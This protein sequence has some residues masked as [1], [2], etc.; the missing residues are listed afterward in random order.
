MCCTDSFQR[1]E[2]LCIIIDNTICSFLLFRQTSMFNSNIYIY[3]YLHDSILDTIATI[4]IFPCRFWTKQTRSRSVKRRGKNSISQRFHRDFTW[5][6]RL[7]DQPGFSSEAF[8]MYDPRIMVGI[9]QT[10]RE[11]VTSL[12]G[13]FL[14]SVS[15]F[16]TIPLAGRKRY[17]AGISFERIDACQ[18]NEFHCCNVVRDSNRLEIN[19]WSIVWN[20]WSFEI[21]RN[22]RTRV[23]KIATKKM[24]TKFLS[25]W[26]IAQMATILRHSLNLLINVSFSFIHYVHF[27]TENQLFT[28]TFSMIIRKIPNLRATSKRSGDFPRGKQRWENEVKFLVSRNA[29]PPF[30]RN[31]QTSVLQ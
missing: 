2:E 12:V 4:W 24:L 18:W 6:S 16:P 9:F 25:F 14:L 21:S 10:V 29:I 1:W 27:P 11:N 7:A 19:Q 26:P 20:D 17:D 30:T 13:R 15:G 31:F 28:T 5:L 22:R 23:D 8:L 3:V